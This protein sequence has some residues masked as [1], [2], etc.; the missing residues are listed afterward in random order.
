VCV[1]VYLT[2]IGNGCVCLCISDVN[3]E[4]CVSLFI[5]DVNMERLCVSLYI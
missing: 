2:L 1:F 3:R 4:S 5:S